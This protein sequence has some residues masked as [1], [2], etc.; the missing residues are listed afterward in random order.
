MHG[1]SAFEGKNHAPVSIDAKRPMPFQV[2]F[3]RMQ[4]PGSCRKIFGPYRLIKSSQLQAQPGRVN[5]L[6]TSLASSLEKTLQAFMP[7]ALDHKSRIVKCS[8]IGYKS[9]CV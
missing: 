6:N 3:Q 7:E 2:T 8:A 1:I 9:S 5:R 4:I